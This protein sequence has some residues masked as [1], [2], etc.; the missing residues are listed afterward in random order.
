MFKI[1]LVIYLIIGA[2]FTGYTVIICSIVNHCIYKIDPDR[3]D[4]PDLYRDIKK[5]CDDMNK[6]SGWS[7]LAEQ[8][9]MVIL[10]PKVI[11]DVYLNKKEL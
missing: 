6:R 11:Y 9:L 3:T 7:H 10:W 8:G 1:F 5:Y 4:H 2:L